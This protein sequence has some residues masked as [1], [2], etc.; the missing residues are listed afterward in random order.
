MF[1][2]AYRMNMFPYS[3]MEIG[4]SFEQTLTDSGGSIL[5]AMDFDEYGRRVYPGMLVP[6]EVYRLRIAGFAGGQVADPLG[7]MA[8][9][10]ADVS[11]D[12]LPVP[13]PSTTGLMAS[14][15]VAVLF[16][17]ARRR[18]SSPR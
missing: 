12:I 18:R 7:E 16:R 10:D 9:V 6:S 17:F 13:E 2:L 5:G 11:F 15:L 3:P 4:A 1:R 14:G 8:Y